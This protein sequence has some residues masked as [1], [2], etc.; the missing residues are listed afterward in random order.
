MATEEVKIRVAVDGAQETAR[1]LERVGSSLESVGD[2][3]AAAGTRTESAS[4]RFAEMART[5][6]TLTQRVQGVAG[7]VQSLVS[8]MGS[9]DRTAGLIAST[10]GTIAQFSALGS[11]LGPAGTV[12]GA[13]A[14]VTVAIL[15][16][17]DASD[18]AA[19]AAGRHADALQRVQRFMAEARRARLDDAARGSG[20]FEGASDADL[21][22]MRLQRREMALAA[23]ADLTN[24]S[25]VTSILGALGVGNSPEELRGAIAQWEY[26]IEQIDEE[27]ARRREAMLTDLERDLDASDA[28]IEDII[29][30]P[31]RRRRS[32]P[33]RPV[34]AM[35]FG[36]QGDIGLPGVS[37]TQEDELERRR[38]LMEERLELV[39]ETSDE[40][41]D[42][43][44]ENLEA[45][46]RALR[47]AA[48]ERKA[49]ATEELE[50]QQQ[51]DEMALQRREEVAQEMGG[52][53][54]GT[55]QLLGGAIKSIVSGEKSAEDA[56]R[57][58][59]AAF[60]E[61]ISQYATLKAATEFADAAASF[62]RYDYAGGAAH[63]GAGLAFT[64]VAVA[65][66]VGA[67]AINSA[68]QAP[69]RPEASSGGGQMARGGDVNII[70]NSPVVTAQTEA[71]LGRSLRG[72]L[73][74]AEAA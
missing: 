3:A 47:E 73:G 65:T 74:A 44:L 38:S 16:M 14:G 39:R 9:H 41:L 12:G 69:A 23:E 21:E 6:Q 48:D 57:G 24:P 70:W 32:G 28:R 55:V 2:Q 42:I 26:E 56:F 19:E 63:I 7:A 58:L 17:A 10:A 54:S 8:A 5:G 52:L 61:M 50:K 64:A 67:A 29:N 20:S 66:G 36:S 18:Q 34:Q 37:R 1:D 43:E 13:I 31:E 45:Y 62:A 35:G 4:D 60:L 15:N 30:G 68:P 25:A 27:V 72:L 46:G 59:A 51:I 53:L 22:A 71:E 40:E 49:L 11:M 33:S